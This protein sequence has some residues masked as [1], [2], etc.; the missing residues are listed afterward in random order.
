LFASVFLLRRKAKEKREFL[1][2]GYEIIRESDANL[3]PYFRLS[4]FALL[5]IA[6]VSWNAE[7]AVSQSRGPVAIFDFHG[8]CRFIK[9]E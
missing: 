5:W 6:Q 2:V 9:N 8:K 4:R 7:E 1:A 3:T